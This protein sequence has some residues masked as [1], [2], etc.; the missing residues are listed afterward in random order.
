MKTSMS[1]VIVPRNQRGDMEQP[2]RAEQIWRGSRWIKVIEFSDPLLWIL[3]G[4][5]VLVW[6]AFINPRMQ[7]IISSRQSKSEVKTL[8]IVHLVLCETIS[9][10][11]Y[12]KFIRFWDSW[13]EKTQKIQTGPKGMELKC[14]NI[15][16]DQALCT[17]CPLQAA[18]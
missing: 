12:Q 7:D 15:E 6:K 8:H 17:I 4:Y 3:K 18:V 2:L 9:H 16:D 13:E 5:S 10:H 1:S 11:I 14:C